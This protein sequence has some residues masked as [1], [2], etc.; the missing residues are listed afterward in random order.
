MKKSICLFILFCIAIC[1]YGQDKVVL[2]DGT[3][4]DVK[5]IESNE[6]EVVFTYP[7]EEV[8]NKKSKSLIDYILYASGRKEVCQSIV[9]PTIESDKDWEKVVVTTN[10]DDV[11]G[12]QMQKSLSVS[13]GNGGVFNSAEKAHEKAI[14]KLKKKVAKLQCGIVL[15]TSDTFGGQYNNISSITG[16]AYK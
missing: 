7:N 6:K 13:A 4:L 3:Q 8:R 14:E 9:I 12:L 11:A 16:E 10:R 1:T 15:I 5:V 2:K